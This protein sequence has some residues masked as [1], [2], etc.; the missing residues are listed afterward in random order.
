MPRATAIGWRAQAALGASG[1]VVTVTAPLTRSVY[2]D[3]AD[4]LVWV[5]PRDG[6]LHPRAV[7]VDVL[8]DAPGGA[9]LHLLIDGLIAW[10]PPRWPPRAPSAETAGRVRATLVG[11]GEPR[12]L[13]RILAANDDDDAVVRYARPLVD[14]LVRACGANDARA[15][16]EAAR[17]LLGLGN[18]LTPSGD[19]LVGGALFAHRLLRGTDAAWGDAVMKITDAAASLTHPISA[20]LLA[21]LAAGDAWAP[22]H[23]L[24]SALASNAMDAAVSA[25]HRVTALGHT[26][27]WDLLTGVLI[28]AAAASVAP[29]I[30]GTT[31]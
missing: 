14:A 23:D 29:E 8:S 18:G 22:L 20:R 30:A 28:V 3:A 19:D 17:P 4:E 21:D 5:G 13:A 1:G 24:L 7:L 31:S 26:S 2:A 15:F 27:G 11:N 10:Q 9:R 12:G 25:G 16:A 6:V